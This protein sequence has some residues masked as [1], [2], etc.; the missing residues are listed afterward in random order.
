MIVRRYSAAARAWDPEV[1]L[2]EVPDLQAYHPEIAVAGEGRAAAT[3]Y[4]LDP[5]NTGAAASF[6][7]FVAFFR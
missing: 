1:I 2:G 4:F 7:V 5:D 6:N 3:F